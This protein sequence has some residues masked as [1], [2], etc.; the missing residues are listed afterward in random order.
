MKLH[1]QRLFACR[2]ERST[3]LRIETVNGRSD[4][5]EAVMRYHKGSGLRE[6]SCF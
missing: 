2:K 3:P 5:V 6:I 1:L 4:S